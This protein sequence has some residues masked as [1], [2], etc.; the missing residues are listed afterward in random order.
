MV[1]TEHM[2]LSDSS[3]A[4]SYNKLLMVNGHNS[5]AA[6]SKTQHANVRRVDD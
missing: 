6:T 3:D 4:S 2:S 5:E 1:P